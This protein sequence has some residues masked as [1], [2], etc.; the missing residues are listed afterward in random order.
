MGWGGGG[1]VGVD[2]YTVRQFLY[3]V[4]NSVSISMLSACLRVYY[5]NCCFKRVVLPV[6]IKVYD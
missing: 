1:G 2:R 3:T 5:Y 4:K 6:F